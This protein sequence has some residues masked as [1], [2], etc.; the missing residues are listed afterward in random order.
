MEI[1]LFK[2]WPSWLV[3]FLNWWPGAAFPILASVFIAW[4]ISVWV[5]VRRRR[6]DRR[7]QPAQGVEGEQLG[8]A[9]PTS[10]R[11]TGAGDDRQPFDERTIARN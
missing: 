9:R 3:S 2:G 7:H 10:D 6:A 8:P 4:L 5:R 1:D 11:I